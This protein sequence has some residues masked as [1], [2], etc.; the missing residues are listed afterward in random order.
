MRGLTRPS[1]DSDMW[2]PD[3]L[4]PSWVCLPNDQ[5]VLTIIKPGESA[6]CVL[7][8]ICKVMAMNRS[9]LHAVEHFNQYHW[10]P[11]HNWVEQKLEMVSMKIPY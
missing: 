1:T 11:S 2:V 3:Q 7:E 6:L 10:L 4:T 8:S 9:R 5:P